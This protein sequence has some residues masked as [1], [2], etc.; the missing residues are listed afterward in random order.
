LAEGIEN[1]SDDNFEEAVL[2]SDLAVLVDFW[3]V[4]CAPCKMIEPSV[5][6][7]AEA[8]KEKMKIVKLNVDENPKTPANYSVMSIPTLLLFKGGEL[9]ET[10]V[11]ALPQKKIE[12]AITKHL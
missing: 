7:L 11:G 4:W 3:A 10:I 5:E 1:V 12:E 6:N 2:K 8:Y 9:K